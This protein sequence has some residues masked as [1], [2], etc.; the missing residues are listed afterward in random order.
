MHLCLEKTVKREPKDAS[1][2]D[3]PNF[4]A[5]LKRFNSWNEMDQIVM[6]IG[7]VL[8]VPFPQNY[9]QF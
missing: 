3:A 4:S 2:P 7:R 5:L 8:T 6:Q 9:I 1:D